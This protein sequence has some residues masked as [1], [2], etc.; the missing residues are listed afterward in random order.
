M[1]SSEEVEV[2]SINDE[3]E[4]EHF[5]CVVESFKLYKYVMNFLEKSNN[6]KNI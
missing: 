6:L 3:K 4:Q 2:E 1:T 5:R